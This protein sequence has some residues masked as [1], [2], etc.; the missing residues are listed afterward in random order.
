MYEIGDTVRIKG[1]TLIVHKDSINGDL[2]LKTPDN[3][4]AYAFH[5]GQL[6]EIPNPAII[7]GDV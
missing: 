7:R 1:V 4:K 6:I 2:I 3:T 5:G